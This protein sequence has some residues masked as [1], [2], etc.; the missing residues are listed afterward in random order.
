L[1]SL[2]GVAA[3]RETRHTDLDALPGDPLEQNR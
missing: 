3:T 2:L 1:I